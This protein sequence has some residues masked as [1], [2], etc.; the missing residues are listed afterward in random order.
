[1]FGFPLDQA[2][3][4]G[5]DQRMPRRLPQSLADIDMPGLPCGCV[6]C[7]ESD[8]A[9]FAVLSQQIIKDDAASGGYVEGVL[10]AEHRDADVGVGF[11]GE[12]RGEDVGVVS[13]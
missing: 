10:A 3:E 2:G 11:G 13:N 4:G 1:M 8:P 6:L 9:P 7:K 5:S 12:I